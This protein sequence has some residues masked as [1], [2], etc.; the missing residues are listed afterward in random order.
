MQMKNLLKILLMDVNEEN[1][2]KINI[3]PLN[4]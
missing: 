4:Q 2:S 1:K 3:T